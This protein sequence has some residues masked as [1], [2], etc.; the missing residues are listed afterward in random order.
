MQNI[1]T[2][3]NILDQADNRAEYNNDILIWTATEY[4]SGYIQDAMTEKADS[5]TG[6]YTGDLLHWVS[7][8]SSAID[9]IDQASAEFGRPD[10]FL[11]E[12][13]QGQYFQH[14]AHL[15]N[16][17]N[18]I[19]KI[20]ALFVLNNGNLEGELSKELAEELEDLELETWEELDQF[21][22]TSAGL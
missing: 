15:Y 8:D 19:Y 14:E 1:L 7:E 17:R 5:Y 2:L 11:K 6:I 21:I 13:Q 9:Y 16:N 10:S 12:I 22:K 3:K 4:N 18:T 20:R